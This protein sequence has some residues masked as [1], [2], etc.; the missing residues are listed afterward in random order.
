MNPPLLTTNKLFYKKWPYKVECLLHR[1]SLIKHVGPEKFAIWISRSRHGISDSDAAELK[2]FFKCVNP[3]LKE[4]LRIRAEGS[5][6][7]LFCG[8]KD[9]FNQIR[10]KLKRWVVKAYSPAND[11]ELA[12]MLNHANKKILCDRFPKELYQYRIYVNVKMNLN[13]RDGFL[14]WTNR[15]GDRIDISTTTKSWLKGFNH[16][17]VVPF[18]YVKDS[19]MLTMVLLFLGNNVKRFEEFILRASINTNIT[20]ETTCHP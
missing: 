1:V 18:L 15:Y 5:H 12:F 2:K 11:E 6:F 10:K 13:S 20:Q 4:D 17:G 9:L 19:A 8:D 16:Q 7:S 3:F 14:T